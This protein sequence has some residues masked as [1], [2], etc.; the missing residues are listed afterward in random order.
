MLTGNHKEAIKR[1]TQKVLETFGKE[2]LR[3]FKFVAIRDAKKARNKKPKEEDSSIE[4]E[5]KVYPG[6]TPEHPLRPRK[7]NKKEI[8]P[9]LKVKITSW[10]TFD[11]DIDPYVAYIVEASRGEQSASVYRRYHH[12]KGLNKMMKKV[13]GL[14]LKK[15][16]PEPKKLGANKLDWDFLHSRKK[17]LTEYLEAIVENKDTHNNEKFLKWLGLTNPE[18]PKFQEIFDIAY[19]NTKWRLWIWK[20]IPYDDEEEAIAKLAIEEIKREVIYDVV[21]P[22]PGQIRSTAAASVYK[23]ISAT[24]G[25]AVSVGWKAAREAIQPLKPK[26]AEIVDNAIEKYLDVEELV[27]GKLIEGINAGLNPMVEAVEPN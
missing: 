27:K 2:Y 22:F 14:E 24:V 23:V 8:V 5:G 26:V 9:E 21:S 13:P 11:D 19:Q 7:N 20:R 4:K 18:D 3:A 1:I 15:K 17:K 10:T 6:S 12:F 25:P 16:L